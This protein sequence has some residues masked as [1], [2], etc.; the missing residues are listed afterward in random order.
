VT[1]P[2]FGIENPF[3]FVADLYTFIIRTILACI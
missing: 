2:Y 3:A 1:Q